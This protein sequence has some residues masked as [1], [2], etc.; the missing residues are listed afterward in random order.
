MRREGTW[1]VVENGYMSVK[2]G[3]GDWGERIGKRGRGLA[4]EER[5]E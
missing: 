5:R 3:L 2:L 1:I 4:I